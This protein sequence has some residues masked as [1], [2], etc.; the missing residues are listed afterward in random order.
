[1]WVHAEHLIL[2]LMEKIKKKERKQEGTKK[3]SAKYILG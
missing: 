1:V 2:F 3:I